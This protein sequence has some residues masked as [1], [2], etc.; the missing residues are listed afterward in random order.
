[1]EPLPIHLHDKVTTNGK[2]KPHIIYRRA[3][4]LDEKQELNAARETREI[5][6]CG[7]EGNTVLTAIV[8]FSNSF[9][10]N[11]FQF[12]VSKAYLGQSNYIYCK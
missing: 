11:G 2:S 4:N 1:M 7:T 5:H 10:S 6:T 3:A 9:V 8:F 12:L